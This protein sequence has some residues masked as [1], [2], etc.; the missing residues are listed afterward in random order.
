MITKNIELIA[1]LLWH[2]STAT[3]DH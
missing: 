2:R 1:S 3:V